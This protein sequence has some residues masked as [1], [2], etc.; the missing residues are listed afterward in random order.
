MTKIKFLRGAAVA[1]ALALA[2]GGGSV[3]A[4]TATA[5]APHAAAD[6]APTTSTPKDPTLLFEEN[7]EHAVT[8]TVIPVKDYVGEKGTT[9]TAAPFWFDPKA[10]NGL[11]V[12]GKGA[13]FSQAPSNSCAD[14]GS[15]Y[16]NLQWMAKSLGGDDNHAVSAY[17]AAN[18]ADNLILSESQGSKL[19]LKKGHF[20][21]SGI[22]VA[23]MNC[24]NSAPNHSKLDFG[25]K[26]GDGNIWFSGNPVVA[27]NGAT[28]TNTPN[29]APG[30]VGSYTGPSYLAPADGTAEYIVRNQTGNG[31]GNDFAFDNLRF[32]DATPTLVKSFKDDSVEVGQPTTVNFTV[33]NTSELAA[34]A[35]WSFT[36]NLPEGMTVAATPNVK[37][38]CAAAEVKADADASKIDITSGTIA[39]GAQTCD[40]SVDVVP[41]KAGDFT[42]VVTSPQGLVGTPSATLKATAVAGTPAA[43]KCSSDGYIFHVE[44]SDAKSTITNVDLKSGNSGAFAKADTDV[45]AVGYNVKDNYVYGVNSANGEVVRIGSDGVTQGL[46][47]TVPVADATKLVT[48]DVDAS[49]NLWVATA[50]SATNT[51]AKWFEIKLPAPDSTDD[52]TLVTSGDIAGK[53]NVIGSDW[54]YLDGTLYTVPDSTNHLVKFDT[55]THEITDLGVV[56]GLPNGGPTS[57]YGV[58]FADP[59]H[60]FFS[61]NGGTGNIY[62]VDPTAKTASLLSTGPKSSFAD[63]ARCPTAPVVAPAPSGT[64][65]LTLAKSASSSLA[66]KV[67]QKIEYTF[68]VANT[69]DAPATDVKVNEGT[70]SGKGKLSAA[71]P[72]SVASLAPGKSATFKASYTVIAGDLTGQPLKNTATAAGIGPDGKSVASNDAAAALGT[73]TPPPAVPDKPQLTVSKAAD[74]ALATK[75]GQVITYTFVARNTGTVALTK[76][77]VNDNGPAGGKGTW[78]TPTCAASKLAVGAQTT[79]TAKYTVAAADINGEALI[80]TAQGTAVGPSGKAIGTDPVVANIAAAAVSTSLTPVDPAPAVPAPAPA[81]P[82]IIAAIAPAPSTPA[83]APST[84][85]AAAQKLPRTGADDSLLA[86]GAAGL[87]MMIIGGGAVAAA[88]RRHR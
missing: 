25:I 66:T 83:A 78:V 84:P 55:S 38:T 6:D 39:K 5:T 36:D 20:Y 52:A 10:C 11:I 48:G 30:A 64:P 44:G 33:V 54:S 60:V 9:Y 71:T 75:P 21:V 79:C 35:G 68:T 50:T 62:D 86:A 87:V 58:S 19:Q 85:A 31:W 67:G 81:A 82:G 32:Y 29:G 69:G 8:N 1:A 53:G 42:N 80:N 28:T 12:Q 74:T 14:E 47:Y 59:T 40:V 16:A 49:G 2:V 41:T 27:C 26:Q 88:R 46:G 76:V 61:Q 3:A 43:W 17:T 7:F 70:F 77:G 34:K 13:D 24:G 37:T 51:N 15:T 73:Q 4:F 65:Q 57:F 56:A 72:A 18:G 22:S 45:N 23:E 63:G